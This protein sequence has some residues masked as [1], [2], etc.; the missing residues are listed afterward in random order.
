MPLVKNQVEYKILG[1][2]I[3]CENHLF[4]QMTS[5][6]EKIQRNHLGGRTWL[7]GCFLVQLDLTSPWIGIMISQRSLCTFPWGKHPSSCATLSHS[8][9]QV[10]QGRKIIQSKLA[11]EKGNLCHAYPQKLGYTSQGWH[12]RKLQYLRNCT[13]DEK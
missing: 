3:F 6:N 12:S 11:R 13:M 2:N 5:W 9:D 4:L 7:Y 1:S 10:A 8:V